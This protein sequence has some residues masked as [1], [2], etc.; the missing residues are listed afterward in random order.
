MASLSAMSLDV[1]KKVPLLDLIDAAILQSARDM[2]IEPF[3]T[4]P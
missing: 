1:V 4:A 2:S 3:R